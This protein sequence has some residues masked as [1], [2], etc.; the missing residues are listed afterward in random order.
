MDTQAVIHEGRTML[1][2][3]VIAEGL[4]KYVYWQDLGIIIISSD[5]KN[6]SETEVKQKLSDIKE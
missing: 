4:G 3:R 2:L 1:P 5:F 6:Y